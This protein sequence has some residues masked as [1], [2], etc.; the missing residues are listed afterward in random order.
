MTALEHHRKPIYFIKKLGCKPD[1]LPGIEDVFNRWQ[2]IGKAGRSK[3]VIYK[4]L[5]LTSSN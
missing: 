4:I 1:D 2:I 3:F 5:L